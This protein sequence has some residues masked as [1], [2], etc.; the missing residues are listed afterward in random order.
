MY[1]TFIEELTVEAEV[2]R[3]NEMSCEELSVY[4]DKT[5]K[6]LHKMIVELENL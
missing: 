5:R 6:D 3:M 4:L 2:A 1:N